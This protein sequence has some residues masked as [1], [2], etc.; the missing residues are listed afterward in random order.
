LYIEETLNRVTQARFSSDGEELAIVCARDPLVVLTLASALAGESTEKKKPERLPRLVPPGSDVAMRLEPASS[1]M[2]LEPVSSV[3]RFEPVSS[4]G[5]EVKFPRVPVS[6]K[7]SEAD[8]LRQAIAR[9]AGTWIS[10]AL[11]D[12]FGRLVNQKLD[13]LEEEPMGTPSAFQQYLRLCKRWLA[14]F[15][16]RDNLDPKEAAENLKALRGYIGRISNSKVH[17]SQR[18]SHFASEFAGS[19]F[20]AICTKKKADAMRSNPRLGEINDAVKL[21]KCIINARRSRIP[22]SSYPS[23]WSVNPF[24]QPDDEEEEG[25]SAMGP[26]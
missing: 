1:S 24:P 19:A 4:S 3:A 14:A 23:P 7:L 9:T 16:D 18:L 5:E 21:I 11:R 10:E 6:A 8:S 13:R 15:D 20:T 22:R 26:E 25:D 12:L 2:R 17:G